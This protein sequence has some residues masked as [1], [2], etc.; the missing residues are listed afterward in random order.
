MRIGTLSFRQ[1][2]ID[3]EVSPSLT[4]VAVL[5]IALGGFIAG[6]VVGRWLEPVSFSFS[7]YLGHL[8]GGLDVGQAQVDV[9]VSLSPLGGHDHLTGGI[10]LSRDYQRRLLL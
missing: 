10:A 2:W 3:R 9:G 7:G 8:D 6:V 5:L 1:R 4:A